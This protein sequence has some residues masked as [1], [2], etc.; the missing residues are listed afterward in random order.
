MMRGLGGVSRE[1]AYGLI[2]RDGAATDLFF[3]QNQVLD[4]HLPPLGARVTFDVQ[5]SGDRL[6]AINVRRLTPA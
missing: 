4:E 6:R 3:H 1:R 5:V 2:R